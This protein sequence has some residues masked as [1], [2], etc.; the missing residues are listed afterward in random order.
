MTGNRE[1][2]KT[3][4]PRD[5]Y[6]GCGIVVEKEDGAVRRVLG[7]PDHRVSRGALCSKCAMA[8][9]GAYLDP[10]KRLQH[11]LRRVGPKGEGKFERVSWDE[12]LSDI[13]ARLT[14]ICDGG[15]SSKVI[16]SHYSGTLGLT[17]Y[18]FPYR[19]FFRLGATEVDPDTVCNMAGHVVLGAMMGDS[20]MGFD[21]RQGDT[22][23]CVVVWGANPS[24]TGP[25]Q[26][27]NWLAELPGK[28]V[29][30]DPIAHATAKAADI[31]LQPRPGTDA[32]LAFALMHVARRDGLVDDTYIAE[33]TIGFDQ[34]VVEIE[35]ATPAWAEGVTGV[36]AAQ[37]E[38][39]GALFGAGPSMMW[40]GQGLQRQAR[41]GNVF[42]A[43][44]TLAAVT[45]NIGKT[46]SG[47]YYLNGPHTKGVDLEPVL[48]PELCGD[49]HPDPISHG[50]LAGALEDPGRSRALFTYNNNI[51]A[52]APNQARLKEA[53]K[54]ED[55]LTVVVDIFETDTA[56]HA[57]YILPAASFL[58]CDDIV[59]PYFDNYTI[60]AQV[61]VMP[62]MGECLSNQEIFRRLAGA[63]GYEEP[64]LFEGDQSIIDHMLGGT[65][66]KG[67]FDDLKKVG[68]TD[69]YDQP[70][71][72][73]A[74]GGFDTPSG[75]IEIACEALAAL[76]HS[77]VPEPHADLPPADGRIRVLSPASDW[78][79]NSSY[80][81]DDKILE[82]MGAP[83][84]WLHPNEA[85][86]RDLADGTAIILENDAGSL[87][88][89]V[90]VSDTVPEG[91]ALVHKSRWPGKM[92]SGA[93]VNIL[94]DGAKS[95][96]GDSSAVHSVEARIVAT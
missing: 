61:Q 39:V 78:L 41:G 83:K 82:R 5:C 55:L 52:S 15:D 53:M 32:A 63:M 90:G 29:V 64:Q 42:R 23:A 38:E 2:I 68:T 86:R 65:P 49:D 56:R 71:N 51:L 67:S 37:I 25:H 34:I 22:A 75:K 74:D 93:N 46:G 95:D 91:V 13:S 35:K 4:C 47:F 31:H 60:S 58:E 40:L 73:F 12:A 21:S 84:A 17:A 79:L 20:A 6:D 44:L 85:A 72:L 10:T 59:S 48:A 16:Y 30:I 33:H 11:P 69:I 9:N 3:T 50:D 54:R 77:L 36:P 94:Y 88:L 43:A 57:D 96:F 8:Y 28:V 1:S 87:P 27:K 89:E 45:G 19:F 66:Y 62:P 24:A 26:H 81:N 14:D 92:N 80:G 18:L 70:R 7:D 76:G